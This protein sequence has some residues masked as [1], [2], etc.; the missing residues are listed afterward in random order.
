MHEA[1]CRYMY[2]YKLHLISAGMSGNRV[3]AGVMLFQR[4]LRVSN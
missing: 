1:L 2:Q 3:Q 4:T